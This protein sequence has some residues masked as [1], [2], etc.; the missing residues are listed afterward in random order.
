M[1]LI[2]S[3][4][5]DIDICANSLKVPYITVPID[6]AK[7]RQIDFHYPQCHPDSSAY[8][9]GLPTDCL[10]STLR[11]RACMLIGREMMIQLMLLVMARRLFY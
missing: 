10:G 6:T 9:D 2:R 5:F 4:A 11:R 1:L 3:E 7:Y 8:P